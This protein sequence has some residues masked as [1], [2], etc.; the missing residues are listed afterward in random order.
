MKYFTGSYIFSALGILAAY[1]W[2]HYSHPG[3]ELGVLFIVLVLSVLE[4]SL[5][6]D[7]AVVNAAKLEKMSPVWQKRFLTWGIWIAVFGMR[8]IF[9]I[10]V[11]SIFAHLGFVDVINLALKDPD[12]Y[13]HYLHI[14]HPPIITFGATFLMMLFLTFFMNAKKEIHWFNFLENKLAIL[15]HVKGLNVVITMLLL[16][17]FH[18]YVGAEYK[19]DVLIAGIW[20]IIVYLL[21]EG[22][23]SALETHADKVKSENKECASPKFN[24]V[25][26]CFINFLYLELIDASF[27]LDGVLGAFALSKDVLIIAIGLS[28]GAMFVRSLTIMLVEKKTLQ[29]YVYLEHGAHYAIGALALIMFVSSFYEVSEIVTGLIGLVFIVAAFICS[30]RENKKRKLQEQIQKIVNKGENND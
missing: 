29:E 11:V 8:L 6:F 27:S 12:K 10:A 25:N 21:I 23:S 3:T 7:N 4:V 16:Y 19:Y 28:I 22:I 24:L 5:S 18:N 2:T 20:G 9:P 26:S 14:S 13:A 17:I 1:L 15:G 30:L